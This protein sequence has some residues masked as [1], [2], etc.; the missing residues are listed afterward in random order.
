MFVFSMTAKGSCVLGG[1]TF[2]LLTN[3]SPNTYLLPCKSPTRI[4][5]SIQASVP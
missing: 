5:D 4:I 2:S 1:K 3:V